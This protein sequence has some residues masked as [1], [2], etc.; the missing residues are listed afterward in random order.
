MKPKVAIV[1]PVFGAV[2][3]LKACIYTIQTHTEWPYEIH[4][5]DDC[6]PHADLQDYLT[7]LEGTGVIIHHG[8]FRRGF[9]GNCNWGVSQTA[10]PLICIL[11]SDVEALPGW[12]TAMATALLEAAYIGLI[13]AR[14]LFPPT[15]GARH[16]GRVQH[17]GVAFNVNGE[18][19]HPFRQFNALAPEVMQ[20]R[21]INAVTGACML[22]RRSLWDSLKGFDES[23]VGGQYEDIDFCHRVRRAGYMIVY[24]PK[25]VLYHFEHGSGVEHVQRTSVR[26]RKLLLERWPDVPCDEHLFGIGEEV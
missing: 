5:S 10:T 1:I 18:P 21:E 17:A 9:P 25:A 2:D 22:L 6:S 12:L 13:G 19:Y 11:N 16:A 23:F 15:R 14:L 26:N 7:T 24:E 4:L 20:R 3:L 8:G